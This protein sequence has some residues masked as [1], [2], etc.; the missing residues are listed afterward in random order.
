M[1][2]QE[3]FEE[4]GWLSLADIFYVVMS[5][6]AGVRVTDNFTKIHRKYDIED[7][8][9]P[10]TLIPTWSGVTRRLQSPLHVI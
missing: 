10:Y 6:R 5:S 3:V 1:V 2:K 9:K 4:A 7:W 8:W